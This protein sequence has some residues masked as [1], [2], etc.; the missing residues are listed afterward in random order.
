MGG[1]AYSDKLHHSRRKSIL[2]DG[3]GSHKANHD[4]RSYSTDRD[5]SSDEESDPDDREE[6]PDTEASNNKLHRKKK[7]KDLEPGLKRIR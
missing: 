3:S 6:S 5:K 1:G 2:K 4:P 7:N